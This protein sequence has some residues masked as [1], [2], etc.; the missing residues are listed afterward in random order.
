M[1]T[2]IKEVEHGEPFMEAAFSAKIGEIYPLMVYTIPS[3]G[4]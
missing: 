2:A 1:R 4:I 3:V